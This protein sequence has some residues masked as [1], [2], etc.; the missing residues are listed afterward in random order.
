CIVV[1]LCTHHRTDDRKPIHHRGDF[2]KHF[3]NLDPGNFGRDRFELASDFLRRFGFDLPHVLVR[4]TSAQEDIDYGLVGAA[5]ASPRLSAQ[6]VGQ[7]QAGGAKSEHTD[8]EKTAPRYTVAH[9]MVLAENRQHGGIDP[10]G[11]KAGYVGVASVGALGQSKTTPAG[12]LK[13]Y[14]ARR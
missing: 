13:V 5:D 4:R 3:A 10:R 7:T 8:L 1:V 2:R 14:H 6:N 11:G 9:P 12:T